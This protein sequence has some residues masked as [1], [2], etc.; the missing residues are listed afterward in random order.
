MK[1]V[2]LG[3]TY[4]GKTSIT[5]RLCKNRFSESKESTIGAAYSS[6]SFDLPN[7]KVKMEIW[8]TSGQE[9][10]KS[11]TP[12]YYRGADVV[13][14]VFDLSNTNTHNEINYWMKMM[15]YLEVNTNNIYIVG[16]K[17]DLVDINQA[18]ID[19]KTVVGVTDKYPDI[20][21]YKVSAKTGFGITE[22]FTNVAE[23]LIEI[24]S[25]RKEN[26][27]KRQSIVD[28]NRNRNGNGNGNGNGNSQ[29]NIFSYC[30]CSF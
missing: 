18:D 16:N 27:S 14:I 10:Y 30:S 12:M 19:D 22:L 28:L 8:D 11:L 23:R 17:S 29:G 26:E 13:L 6:V 24:E 3:D 20:K 7:S 21:F 4:V 2:L 9:R 5:E 1:L 15:K 25:I